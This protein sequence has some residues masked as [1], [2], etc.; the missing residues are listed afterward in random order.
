MNL[1][2]FFGISI[3]LRRNCREGAIAFQLSPPQIVS[4][5]LRLGSSCHA[6][7]PFTPSQAALTHGQ[8]PPELEKKK[9]LPLM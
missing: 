3:L 7:G 6:P 9:R 2:F 8:K 1:I 5:Q 4:G